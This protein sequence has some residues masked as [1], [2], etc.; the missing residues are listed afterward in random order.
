MEPAL[1]VLDLDYPRHHKPTT[2]RRE[3]S[4]RGI[5]NR[6]GS[7]VLYRARGVIGILM[8][9]RDGYFYFERCKNSMPPSSRHRTFGVQRS[10]TRQLATQTAPS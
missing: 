5:K 10:R 3:E 4:S 1:N 9:A 2:R 6:Y 8:L 7:Y